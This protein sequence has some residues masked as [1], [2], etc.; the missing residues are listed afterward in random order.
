MSK[1]GRRRIDPLAGDPINPEETVNEE[2]VESEPEV[3]S[4]ENN[5]EVPEET[6]AVQEPE[7]MDPQPVTPEVESVPEEQPVVPE[8]AVEEVTEEAERPQPQVIV[9]PHY[10]AEKKNQTG[11]YRLC[12]VKDASPLKW[13]N[14]K[15]KIKGV[16]FV[17]F[18]VDEETHTIY[19][20]QIGSK[21]E[22][23]TIKKLLQGKGLKPVMENL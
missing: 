12:I 2:V 13:I 8:P 5:V 1:K 21:S 19:S 22:A 20:R 16:N 18:D 6:V 11:R 9:K 4:A 17:S 3:L 7:P 14:I 10:D 15:N 23:N